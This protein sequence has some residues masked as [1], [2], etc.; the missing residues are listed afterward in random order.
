MLWRCALMV[1]RKRVP[2]HA[3]SM[4]QS[5]FV[6]SISFLTEGELPSG[7]EHA[8]YAGRF[9]SEKIAPTDRV[10]APAFV[11]DQEWLLSVAQLY[12]AS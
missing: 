4:H 9:R 10:H 3:T 8:L 5:D 6:P 1:I 12:A 7:A 2:I 11:V